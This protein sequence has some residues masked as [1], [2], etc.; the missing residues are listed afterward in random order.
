[1]NEKWK[2][3]HTTAHLHLSKQSTIKYFSNIIVESL[4]LTVALIVIISSF[5]LNS[6]SFLYFFYHSCFYVRI[7]KTYVRMLEQAY[8]FSIFFSHTLQIRSNIQRNLLSSSAIDEYAFKM[9]NA[10]ALLRS[11]IRNSFA[12]IA[13]IRTI[14][15][16]HSDGL[17][18]QSNIMIFIAV[19]RSAYDN[20]DDWTFQ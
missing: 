1:M 7:M 8:D 13:I 16:E 12:N 20:N 2:L 19:S 17:P 3:T 9:Y 10:N 6:F 4:T 14:Q 11:H 5:T 15:T 18:T